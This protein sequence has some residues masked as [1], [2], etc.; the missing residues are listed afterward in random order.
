MEIGR[1]INPSSW[2]RS[3][4][5]DLAFFMNRLN[6]F[7]VRNSNVVTATIGTMSLIGL[8]FGFSG[9]V[10]R[11]LRFSSSFSKSSV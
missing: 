4:Q 9:V 2:L 10:V 3:D 1:S 7:F 11:R 5:K 8:I 6:M